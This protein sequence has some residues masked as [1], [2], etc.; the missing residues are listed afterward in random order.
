MV[1]SRLHDHLAEFADKLRREP[2]TARTAEVLY[3]YGSLFRNDWKK[4]RTI[5][6]P[7]GGVPIPPPRDQGLHPHGCTVREAY[8]HF[9]FELGSVAQ[10]PQHV[11]PKLADFQVRVL[12]NLKL[13]HCEVGLEDHWRVD[14]DRYAIASR[15]RE[16]HPYFHFQRGGYLQDGFAGQDGFVPGHALPASTAATPW[17]GLLQSPGPRIPLPPMCPVLAIDFTISQHDGTVWRRLRENPEYHAIVRA[18]QA[19]LWTPFFDA[20]ASHD[21]R[22][23][24]FGALIV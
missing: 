21:L 8:I 15:P 1:W 4:G 7:E 16:P 12:G 17:R 9:E 11:F 20:M 2:A 5:K 24:W 10:T 23:R 13:S 14:T 3:T 22:R 18:A 6:S 19:R